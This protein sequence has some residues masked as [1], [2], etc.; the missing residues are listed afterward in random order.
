MPEICELGEKE[1]QRRGSV[2]PLKFSV[3]KDSKS[4][5]SQFTFNTQFCLSNKSHRYIFP[6]RLLS[7]LGPRMISLRTE[8]LKN[9][10]HNST[11][12]S[13]FFIN[14]STMQ[15]GKTAV[16]C[17]VHLSQEQLP[18]WQYEIKRIVYVSSLLVPQLNIFDLLKLIQKHRSWLNSGHLSSNSDTHLVMKW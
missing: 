1:I 18:A 11:A 14:R 12:I 3:K 10:V 2:S 4:G 6:E 16:D 7:C 17:K 8:L 13:Y 9:K 15:L 5:E